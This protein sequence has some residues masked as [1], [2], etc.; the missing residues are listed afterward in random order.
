MR[1]IFLV[2]L[3]STAFI[4]NA[5]DIEAGKAKATLCAAC[6]GA[7][8]ISADPVYPNLAGQ[9][10]SYLVEQIKAF[11]SGERSSA[12]MKPMVET[13]TDEEIANLAAYLSSLPASGK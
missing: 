12:I 6:H 1:K 5:G 9:K 7:N 11:R 13:L 10:E 2:I 3:M 4:V 8:G